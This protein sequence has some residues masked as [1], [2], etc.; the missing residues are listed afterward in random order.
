MNPSWKRL[1]ALRNAAGVGLVTA[2]FLLVV[3]A[4]LGV[5]IVSVVTTQQTEAAQDLLGARAYQAARAGIEWAA[6]ENSKSL[7]VCPSAAGYT[8]QLPTGTTLSTFTA[9]VT[10]TAP[11]TL[12][13]TGPH[14]L[15]RSTACNQPGSSGCPNTAPSSP[16]YVQRVVEV[17]L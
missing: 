11:V 2:I 13:N 6:Y 15:I 7:L 16:D 5:A 9:T 3:L 10:C 4:G 8:F 17:Q 12:G 14:F 1:R